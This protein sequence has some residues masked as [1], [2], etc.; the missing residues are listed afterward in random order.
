MKV[1]DLTTRFSI[2]KNVYKCD[3]CPAT[4]SAGEIEAKVWPDNIK[5]IGTHG[6]IFNDK[7]YALHCPKCGKV[8]LQ[9]FNTVEKETVSV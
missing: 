7:E 3:E 8:H 9:G 5:I 1:G 6:F 2:D 4:F